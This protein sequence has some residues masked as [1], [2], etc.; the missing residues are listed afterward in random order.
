M[1]PS[2][3]SRRVTIAWVLGAL[4]VAAH[5]VSPAGRAGVLHLG[6]IPDEL[7]WRL[8]WMLLAWLYLEWFCRTIWRDATPGA[9]AAH[10]E[11]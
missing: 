9:G 8:A 4:L 5:L 6:W 11:E 7:A 10:E 1:R 2:S 3:S